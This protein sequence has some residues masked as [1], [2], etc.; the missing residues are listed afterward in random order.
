[1]YK[2]ALSVKEEIENENKSKKPGSIFHYPNIRLLLTF[3]NAYSVWL[4][5]I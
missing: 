4:K 5:R 1:M 3:H 2:D